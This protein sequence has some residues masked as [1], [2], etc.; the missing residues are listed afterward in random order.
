MIENCEPAARRLRRGS[1]LFEGKVKGFEMKAQDETQAFSK[2]R[3]KGS[4]VVSEI[5]D[6]MKRGLS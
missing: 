1:N 4:K 6:E 2:V 3:L 5:E